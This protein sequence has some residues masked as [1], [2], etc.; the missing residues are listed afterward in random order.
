MRP[1]GFKKR[2]GDLEIGCASISI[3]SGPFQGVSIFSHSMYNPDNPTLTP[4]EADVLRLLVDE[5]MNYSEVARFLH[6]SP[7]T[8]QLHLT[9]LAVKR[10]ADK[11]GRIVEMELRRKL[12]ALLAPSS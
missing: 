11:P 12:K 3:R 9:R 7:K 6:I 5:G 4:R 10:G 8:L 1:N 2:I